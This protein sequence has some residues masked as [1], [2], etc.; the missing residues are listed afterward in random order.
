VSQESTE[1][2]IAFRLGNVAH[3][4]LMQIQNIFLKGGATSVISLN[5]FFDSITELEEA[6]GPKAD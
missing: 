1:I 3:S 5:E 4:L 2:L 6:H